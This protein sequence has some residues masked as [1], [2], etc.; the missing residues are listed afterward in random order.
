M[1]DELHTIVMKDWW[2][3]DSKPRPDGVWLIDNLTD[4]HSSYE[5]QTWI[6]EEVVEAQQIQIK[7]LQEMITG[8]LTWDDMSEDFLERNR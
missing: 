3:E 6:K 8:G 7:C 1:T 4:C 5:V 2:P